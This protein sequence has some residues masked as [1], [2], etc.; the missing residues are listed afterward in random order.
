M[1]VLLVQGGFGAGGA[2]KVVAM[3]AAHRAGRGDD[4]HIAGMT[5]PEG[6]SYFSYPEAVTLHPM[7]SGA[8]PRRRVQWNRL[9][10]IRQVIKK[11]RPDVVVSFLTKINTLTL[12]ATLDSRIPVVISERNNPRAQ[13]AHPVWRQA[14]HL[15]ARR[16]RAIVMQTDR[17][18][19]DLPAGLRGRA[20]V[21]A[22]P[23]APFPGVEE[24]LGRNGS[25]LVAVGR[26]DRQKGFD[27]LID[28][29]TD[30]RDRVPDAHLTIYGEGSERQ[31]LEDQRDRL[32]LTD[33]VSLPGSSN[34]PGD[35]MKGA[36]ILVFPSRFEGFP[37]VV[38]E[39]TVSGLPV[40]SA[41]CAYGPRELIRQEENGLLVPSEDA[42]ALS[43]AVVRL[44]QDPELRARM[45][46][47]AER[48]RLWLAP[49]YVLGE[50][51]RVID[52]TQFG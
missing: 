13:N 31:A 51:D 33:V 49:K 35:W 7:Q 46:E 45:R 8:L 34:K 17:A 52:G 11:V 10:H 39:A 26:L 23:C 20:E 47:S 14:Q 24:G 48:N 38:A 30:I 50:W 44:S 37:N 25:Q 5:M 41:D 29:M 2:E 3:I 27:I 12:A 42:K 36:D 6:G 1:K 4:V 43:A 21:I 28:A 19:E 22:N 40:V 16:A 18:R 15:L 32:G 9:R